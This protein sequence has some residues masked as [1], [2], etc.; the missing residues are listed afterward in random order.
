MIDEEICDTCQTIFN[1][2]AGTLELGNDTTICDFRPLELS[3][4]PRFVWMMKSS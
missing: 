1:Q 4:E 3:L 2:I